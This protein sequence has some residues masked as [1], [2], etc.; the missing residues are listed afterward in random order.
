[1]VIKPDLL[2]PTYDC[3]RDDQLI[4]D[5]DNPEYFTLIFGP[6]DSKPAG[7]C[8]VL[9]GE[10]DG[11]LYNW[12]PY[13]GPTPYLVYRQ[14]VASPDFAEATLYFGSNPAHDDP[15]DTGQ[16]AEHMGD[17]YPRSTYCSPQELEP[18]LC[19]LRPW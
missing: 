7:L 14:L 6:I 17:Y 18:D 4:S 15:F 9:E 3:V 16:L 11:C 12:I 8:N 5:P 19:G 2:N 1:V 13:A 10:R